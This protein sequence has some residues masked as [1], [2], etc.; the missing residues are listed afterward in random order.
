[1]SVFVVTYWRDE[2]SHSNRLSNGDHTLGGG[3][4]GNGLTILPPHLLGK[5]LKERCCKANLTCC[6]TQWLAL[7]NAKGEELGP[8]YVV[9]VTDLIDSYH[10][11][12]GMVNWILVILIKFTKNTIIP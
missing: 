2:C 8:Y 12:H 9:K 3:G 7:G 11:F 10:F 1:M 5:P 6:L 4:T